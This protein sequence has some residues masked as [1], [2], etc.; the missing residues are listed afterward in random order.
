MQ[1]S[2]LWHIK[3]FLLTN[4]S[5]QQIIGEMYISVKKGMIGGYFNGKEASVQRSVRAGMK[6]KSLKFPKTLW[7]KDIPKY[8][9]VLERVK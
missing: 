2:K 3:L 6:T 5:L 7:S 9:I 1:F 8:R 4:C